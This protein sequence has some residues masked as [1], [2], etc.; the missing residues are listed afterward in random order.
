MSDYKSSNTGKSGS[1]KLKVEVTPAI[2]IVAIA[3]LVI[4][5]GAGAFYAY[6]GGWKTDGQKDDIYKHEILPLLAAKRGD[7][8]ALDN[9]NKL[10]KEHGQPLLEL[11]NDRGQTAANN[12][13][14]LEELQLKL[15]AAKGNSTTN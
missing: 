1:V 7:N 14:R 3:F 2:M 10:R 5:L 6:N 12:K 8:T 11:P 4:I 15:N 9:E 13:Q